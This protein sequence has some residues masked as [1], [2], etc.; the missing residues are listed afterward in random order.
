[1]TQQT[2]TQWPYAV[3]RFA[4]HLCGNCCRGDGFVELTN[5][6]VKRIAAFL[7][8]TR[9]EFLDRYC[10]LDEKTMRWHLIDQRD[11]LKSCVF[12]QKDNKCSINDVKPQQ[13]RDFP[14]KWRPD[15][16][17][18]FCEGWRAAAGLP[19]PRKRTMTE[20]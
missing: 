3:G 14:T 13:C 4:C 20:E 11:A 6:D 10:K 19:P 7:E 12:L 17:A 16:I 8:L 5:A 1:M 15:N 2:E 18:D 9:E